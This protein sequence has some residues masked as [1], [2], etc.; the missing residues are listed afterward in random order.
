MSTETD[1]TVA[2]EV[3][4]RV[5][6]RALDIAIALVLL[7]WGVVVM[8]DSRRMGMGWTSDG[9]AAGFFSFYIG[10]LLSAACL[11][12]IVRALITKRAPEYSHILTGAHA[13]GL[14]A[15]LVPTL[16]LVAV[17]PFTGLYAAA[18]VY[19]LWFARREAKLGWLA[20]FGLSLATALSLF[21]IFKLGFDV[22]LPTGPIE[23]WLGY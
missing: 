15:A 14:A 4:P 21:A 11:G 20:S 3:T 22:P 7:G 1:R 10:A 13:R 18:A 12:V 23:L 2:A 5:S 6:R 19:L 8:I 16:V 17:M 9:P